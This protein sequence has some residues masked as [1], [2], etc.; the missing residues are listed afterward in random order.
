MNFRGFG[1]RV[2]E[3]V[4]DGEGEVEVDAEVVADGLATG[5]SSDPQ[6]DASINDTAA[7]TA[8]SHRIG[9]VCHDLRVSWGGCCRG[10]VIIDNG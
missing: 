9:T 3:G 10:S 2:G 7:P 5:S 6:A 8:H 4:G 1:V